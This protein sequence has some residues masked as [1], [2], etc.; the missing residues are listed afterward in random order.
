ME[1][2]QGTTAPVGAT[3]PAAGA[4]ASGR[5]TLVP[6]HH[7]QC[8]ELSGMLRG[9]LCE[10][11][12]RRPAR[13]VLHGEFLYFAGEPARSLYFLRRGLVKTSRVAPDGREL[14]LQL[15]RPG[16]IFGELCFC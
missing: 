16:E 13:R 11:L 10:Q 7:A 14:I 15:H 8:L 4:G 3:P 5:S 12:S 1:V 9:K 6:V 2:E